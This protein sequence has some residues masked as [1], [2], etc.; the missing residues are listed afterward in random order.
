[1]IEVLDALSVSGS[2]KRANEDG[3]GTTGDYAWVI[4]GA[5]GLGDEAL[6]DAPSDAA[7][8]TAALHEALMDGAAAAD[9]PLSLMR[10]AAATAEARF[11][12]ERSRPPRERYEIPTAALM[13]VR[14]GEVVEVAEMG[15][16]G[17]FVETDGTVTRFGGM[18]RQRQWEADSALRLMAG[19]KGRTPEVTA[20]LR[21]VRNTANTQNGYAVFAPDIGCMRYVRQHVLGARAGRALLVSDGFEA[22]ID[23]YSLHDGA[24][25]VDAAARDAVGVLAA[26]R[27]VEADDP[28]CMRYPRFKP[29]DDATALALSFTPD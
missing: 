15:D 6:L 25:L 22:A 21:T 28:H 24:S 11:V 19:G 9:G 20:Y 18:D 7:W 4:D 2:P 14:F 12:A 5:T 16:C 17:L 8:L 1:M 27:A 29:S 3:Y 23:D 26:I 13:L 10:H